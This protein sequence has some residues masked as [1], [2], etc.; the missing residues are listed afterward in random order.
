MSMNSVVAARNTLPRLRWLHIASL[1]IFSVAGA[2]AL[3]PAL[4]VDYVWNQTG[5][6]GPQEWNTATNWTPA[7]PPQGGDGNNAHIGM[8]GT[9]LIDTAGGPV[10]AIDS[11]L[12][13][14]PLGGT[15]NQSDQALTLAGT[16]AVANPARP[17]TL[18]IGVN[19]GTTTGVG[20][21]NLTGTGSI[22]AYNFNIGENGGSGAPVST[23]NQGVIGDGGT[24]TVTITNQ[25]GVGAVPS[26]IP[27]SGR[28]YI[29][30]AI[31]S[32]GNGGGNGV[33]NLNSGSLDV[34][35]ESNNT[36]NG[37]L[38]IGHNA[39]HG[40][41]NIHG[42]TI[43]V[44]NGD[45][46]LADN[47]NTIG[48]SVG[49]VNQDGGTANYE[50]G[51]QGNWVFVGGGGTGQGTYNLS[52][53]AVMNVGARLVIARTAA[54][55]TGTF[56]ISGN[57][58]L[59]TGSDLDV[60]NGGVGVFNQSGNTTVNTSNGWLFV[61]TSGN[62]GSSGTYNLKSGT[63]TT[64]RLVVGAN[65]SN[66]SNGGIGHFIQTGGTLT[67]T[68]DLSLGDG[69]GFTGDYTLSGPSTGPNAVTVTTGTVVENGNSNHGM[70][71][72]WGGTG[73]MIQNGGQVIVGQAGV[74]FNGGNV[75]TGNGTY[76]LNSGILTTP[77][78]FKI[79]GPGT[80]TFN[81]NGGILQAVLPDSTNPNL[82]RQVFMGPGNNNLADGTPLPALTA[83][84]VQAGGA[85]IDSN[86]L[87]INI[88]QPLLNGVAG[89][90]GGLTLADSNTTPGS[91]TLSGV[92]TYNGNT[93]V[94]AGTLILGNSLALHNSTLNL[95]VNN[96]VQ[97]APGV[98]PFTL[99]GLT[100]GGNLL[101]QDT[102]AAAVT[103]S[104]GNNN[105]NTTYNGV[106]SD[107]GVGSGLN[108]VGTGTL[109]L[110]AAQT[111]TGPTAV[112]GGTLALASTASL[113]G[114]V[115]VG[116]AAATGN[117]TI[118]GTGTINGSLT[119][120]APNGGVGGHAAPGTASAIGILHVGSLSLGAGSNLDFKF[121][122]PGTGDLIA[123]TGALALP[124]AG[125]V[126]VNLTNTGGFAIGT[127]KLITESSTTNFST[128][129]FSVG[130][131]IPGFQEAF[132][133]PS[134]TEI[135]M[136]VSPA[137]TW[138]SVAADTNWAN[139]AN[140]VG[141][142][143]PGSTSGT[144]NTDLAAFSSGSNILNPMPDAGRNVQ[145]ITFDQP[146]VGA[147]VIGTAAGNA[148]L[149][150]S[151]GK[152]QTTAMDGATQTVNA[153]LVL[154]GA[155]GTYTFSSN[156]SNNANLL[157]F[158][159]G[160]TGGAAGNTILTLTG[161]NTGAN[162]IAGVIGNGSATSLSLFKSG[163]GTWVL[164]GNN[165]FTGGVTVDGGTL[166]VGNA[167]AL[168]STTPNSVTFTAVSTG[169]LALNGNN[170]TIASLNSTGTTGQ[171]VD[172]NAAG[173]TLTIATAGNPTYS[174]ILA[175]GA[176]GGALSLT[177]NGGAGTSQTLSGNNTFS[178]TTRVTGAGT[179]ILASTNALQNSTLNMTVVGSVQFAPTI[180]N[181]TLG[182]LSGSA[183]LTLAD[184]GP[185]AINLSVGNNGANTTYSGVLDD[186]NLG[187]TL[188]KVGAG[189][190]TLTNV[191]TY[192]GTTTVNA[193]T[194][195]F[196]NAGPQTFGGT[197][198]GSGIV[199]A[200][201]PGALTL[202]SG[203]STWSG[204][205]N[206][207]AGVTVNAGPW[208][209]AG[210]NSSPLGAGATTLNAGS[211]LNLAGAGTGTSPPP[212]DPTQNYPGGVNIAGNSTINVTNSLAASMGTSSIGATLNLTGD[213]G[214]SLSL[215]TT[216]LNGAAILNPAANTTLSLG[217]T[218]ESGG[219]QSLTKNGAGTA[220]M[221]SPSTYSGG[222]TMN[223]GLLNVVSG[224]SLGTGT[225]TLHG[226]TLALTPNTTK[227]ISIHF[228]GGSNGGAPTLINA[229][230][231]A[232][233]IPT[234]NW[235]NVNST[236]V[237][238]TPG[239][240]TNTNID[241]P[242]PA[243]IADSNGNPTNV[244][245]AF[246]S[247]NT[248]GT[249]VTTGGG[250]GDIALMNGYLD[251]NFGGNNFTEVALKGIPFAS[252]DVYAYVGSDG[253]GRT[254]HGTINGKSIYFITSDSP[255]SWTGAYVQGIGTSV[256][257]ANAANYILFQSVAGP[258]MTY[259][260]MGDNNNVGLHGIEII[261]DETQISM[262]NALTLTGNATIA[263]NGSAAGAINGAVSIGSQTLSVTGTS[264]GTDAPYILTLGATTLSGNPI[265]DVANN[266][267]GTGTLRLASINDGGSARTITKTN[268]GTLEIQGA[269][270][271]TSGT[272]F[273][274]NVGRLRFNNTTSGPAIVGSGVS[275]TVASGATLELAGTVS[276]LSSP[277]PA[278]ARVNVINNSTQASGGSLSVTGTNQQVGAITGTGDTVVSAGASLTANSIVQNALVI[279]GTATSPATVTIAASDASGNPLA[280]SSALVVAGSLS[281]S[282]APIAAP[283]PGASG[284]S[285][286]GGSL[287]LGGTG[288][289][290]G[291]TAVPEPSTFVLLALGGIAVSLL[292]ARR[293][294][295]HF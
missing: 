153:P 243:V 277:S 168:N 192:T 81:F 59:T 146:G 54:G 171:V 232:G 71:L 185:T 163:A 115:T 39:G 128:T 19:V 110:T 210:P 230:D 16:E 229:T 123:S 258:N 158:G 139:A 31:G 270:T 155:N 193:G 286:T 5:A 222:T 214:A 66:G 88:S 92:N 157:N 17:G 262:A 205:L 50:M 212:F 265:F 226:G 44:D 221:A 49:I 62:A 223:Q 275:I 91:L 107:G 235:N 227:A 98:T 58:Q 170:A 216:T 134:G 113:A 2:V 194:L 267:A 105:S 104:V 21:Y 206:V 166:R 203:S 249:G 142:L 106:L 76:N 252:Y 241:G 177:V 69:A 43:T 30:G 239:S 295:R 215:G 60:D 99:G 56:N 154:E 199:T 122:A 269:S 15:V 42:G 47:S 181:F 178:G 147:F 161:N 180:T 220:I 183:N 218:G 236:G 26:T 38:F 70:L 253:D 18:R 28:M 87:A 37:S 64:G 191:P 201:G 127:Y 198:L 67:S 77:A 159:G 94:T 73:T 20:T 138:N 34:S 11:I 109:T 135:D 292:S 119:V 129:R 33:Y 187:S 197:I 195:A 101:L 131:A 78:I 23:F 125:S 7:G 32:G 231:T 242:L 156:S 45:M 266:G 136:I 288:T 96:S 283:S 121:G 279:G 12:F 40:T 272:S 10:A 190:L 281:S 217:P 264:T 51:G 278:S 93:N 200:S 256:A 202:T 291:T 255:A 75:S 173:A 250:P 3:R 22:S 196:G 251:L 48:P 61:G 35:G 52:G 144:T 57:A 150:T 145:N 114:N 294:R 14:D 219:S 280:T 108:K 182:G 102:A 162:T 148:L 29:G 238:N 4:A 274:A 169:T 83:A 27:N 273:K 89:T 247:N 13:D 186:A 208:L 8:G 63:V 285:S 36:G 276:D 80:G 245:I 160:I 184:T 132:S 287:G 6:M 24:T 257:T 79:S 189:T 95:T 284:L 116:G 233:V 174:A 225:I 246:Q 133:N 53:D 237:S 167:G 112:N 268:A 165:T 137:P 100:G 261:N 289:V 149:L 68:N 254:G 176:G 124:A 152:V 260:Q 213:S 117:P 55:G 72:G 120:S 293:R 271:L 111:Y 118:S 290:G 263:V 140:W 84:N 209:T 97:F 1:V 9:A 172:G 207:A 82:V 85:I 65:T 151:G 143:I 204:G 244:S 74:G 188:T 41:L 164:G 175:D 259:D 228:E 103:I 179:L 46:F 126:T 234:L 240:G 248:W 25:G 211:T 141:G 86:G 282:S 130:V 224:K 90:D